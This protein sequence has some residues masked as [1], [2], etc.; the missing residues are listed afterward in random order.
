MCSADATVVTTVTATDPDGDLF[1][2]KISNSSS[3][4]FSIDPNSGVIVVNTTLGWLDYELKSSYNVTVTVQELA[5]SR[6][7]PL[8]ASITVSIIVLDVREPPYFA[9][10]TLPEGGQMKMF[11]LDSPGFDLGK[12]LFEQDAS[13]SYTVR[14]LDPIGSDPYSMFSV[15][16]EGEVT[17][18]Q[19]VNYQ[20][21]PFLYFNVRANDT[22]NS[23]L[24]TDVRIDVAIVNVNEA[25]TLT[26]LASSIL[27]VDEEFVGV[28]TGVSTLTMTDPDNNDTEIFNITSATTPF[29]LVIVPVRTGLH[30]F[31]SYWNITIGQPPGALQMSIRLH[32]IGGL[33][34][35]ATCTVI[36]SFQQINHAPVWLITQLNT[37]VHELAPAGTFLL[38]LLAAD[39][40]T[41]QNITFGL[42][43]SDPYYS[44]NLFNLTSTDRGVGTMTLQ[45]NHLDYELVR[46]YNISIRVTDDGQWTVASVP[47]QL[48]A[49]ISVTIYVIDDDDSPVVFSVTGGSAFGMST[50][51]GEFI[52]IDGRYFGAAVPGYALPDGGSKSWTDSTGAQINIKASVP[53][54]LGVGCTQHIIC[55][56]QL[57]FRVAFAAMLAAGPVL[58]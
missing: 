57:R 41:L 4:P 29:P 34:A 55:G 51:G 14:M 36:I 8:N 37:S 30:T 24:Y 40:D 22:C 2:F 12:V 17:V 33:Y 54:S 44:L 53:V 15:T 10:P 58:G 50:S 19:R 27:N 43:P 46:Y 38:P 48:F 56:L 35:T 32:D 21:T 18:L 26:C 47:P 11:E 23:S 49:D 45:T 5:A 42:T 7:L 3:G 9:M 20:S 6:D 16:S 1:Y 52:T 28:L 25:P 31:D 13:C 39:Q